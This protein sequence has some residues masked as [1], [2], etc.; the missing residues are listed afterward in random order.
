[1]ELKSLLLKLDSGHYQRA[2]HLYRRRYQ[3]LKNR[4]LTRFSCCDLCNCPCGRYTLLCQTC[5]DDLPVFASDRINGDLLNWPAVAK[6]LPKISFDHLLCFAPYQWPFSQWL[7]QL[8][9]QGRFE[10]AAL[11][12]RLL[13]DY[14]LLQCKL[15]QIP[16]PDLVLA[17]PL[18]L[19]KWQQRGYNQAHIIAKSFAEQLGY[20]YRVDVLSRLRK[21]SSQVGQSG[22]SRRKNLRKAF[23]VHGRDL[24]AHVLLIDDVITTGTTTSEVSKCLKQ[25]GVKKV[26]VLTLCLTL[27]K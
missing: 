21:T 27:P 23:A 1:M 19:S 15:H 5:F 24:P 6:A 20:P 14:W 9:Y 18:H 4:L 22:A 25:H 2:A 26:T 17:V 16:E 13:A 8:K 3:Q 12:A 11:L 7:S 10:L